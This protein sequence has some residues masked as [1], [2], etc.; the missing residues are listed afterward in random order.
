MKK[1]ILIGLLILGNFTSFAQ[2]KKAEEL[3]YKSVKK[4][5][6]FGELSNFLY[7]NKESVYS[8]EII[9]QLYRICLKS[10]SYEHIDRL[11]N[12]ILAIPIENWTEETIKYSKNIS[13]LKTNILYSK[14]IDKNISSIERFIEYF[15]NFPKDRVKKD[16]DS[17]LEIDKQNFKKAKITNTLNAL[18]FYIKNN[19][20]GKHLENANILKKELPVVKNLKA[21]TNNNKIDIYFDINIIEANEY[22]FIGIENNI[23]IKMRHILNNVNTYKQSGR[24]KITWDVLKDTDA[25]EGKVEFKVNVKAK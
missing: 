24:Y 22:K 6:N 23:G 2:N 9:K 11:S 10:N 21:I 8:T 12:I 4:S 18:N 14:K 1:T 20:D 19:P 7:K 15:P 3:L 16:L 5:N 13:I 25:L 17:L